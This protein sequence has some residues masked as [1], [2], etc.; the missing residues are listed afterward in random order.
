VDNSDL[1]AA[2]TYLGHRVNLTGGAFLFNNYYSAA[3]TSV[4]EL[5]TEDTLF[6][7]RNYGFYGRASY[8]L[9][10]FRRLDFDMQIFNSDRTD[11]E[12]DDLGYLS[13]AGRRRSRLLQPSLSFVHDNALFDLHGPVAGSR[14]H[15]SYA[16]GLPISSS[17]LD[18]WTAVADVRKYW[19]PWRRNS[20]ALR[21]TYAQSGGADPRSFIIGGPWT[22]RGYHYYDYQRIS[23][24]AG[25]KLAL[26]SV[27]YR[28]PLID[29]LIFGWPGR[30][31]L[32]GIGGALFFDAGGA[33]SG[34]IRF[35]E[36]GRFADLRGNIGLGLRTNIFFL[37]L[38][39]DWA[40]PTDMQRLYDSRFHFSI[41]S[42]F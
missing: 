42:N 30:W 4:G 40:W 34:D 19:T 22:L 32:S 12:I 17:S 7:E 14:V 13:P 26:M 23:G 1:A 38:K 29:Y 36:R 24:L 9:S 11:F 18:R 6:R 3:I 31:G 20:L 15:L 5:L 16:R 39:F 33:W 2:Y 27:E 35:F 25:T 10:I 8:P 28:L 37:P 41:G 21:L